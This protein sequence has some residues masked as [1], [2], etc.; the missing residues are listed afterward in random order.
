MK[1]LFLLISLLIST[2]CYSQ[3]EFNEVFENLLMY[4]NFQD[5]YKDYSESWIDNDIEECNPNT[6]LGSGSYGWR[7]YNASWDSNT[8]NQQ[9]GTHCIEVRKTGNSG[10]AWSHNSYWGWSKRTGSQVDS[11]Q[12]SVYV[13]NPDASNIDTIFFGFGNTYIRGNATIYD[14]DT[15]T[16]KGSWIK[17]TIS[18]YTGFGSYIWLTAPDGE[19]DTFYIDNFKIRSRIFLDN[20]IYSNYLKI[21]NG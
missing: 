2:T 1:K 13:F 15:I 7:K 12:L 21:L 9:S 6:M 8:V 11:L 4:F 17:S 19:N 10:G 3:I 18:W 20:S 5:G 16:T 14:E